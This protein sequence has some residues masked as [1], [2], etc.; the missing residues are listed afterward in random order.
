MNFM[1]FSGLSYTGIQPMLS[2][3]GGEFSSAELCYCDLPLI[4]G[5]RLVSLS[6]TKSLGIAL[7][8]AATGAG[9]ASLS[10]LAEDIWSLRYLT[11]LHQHISVL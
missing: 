7:S 6:V 4:K 11:G 2:H 3:G 8:L 9:S 10:V 1:E 5:H